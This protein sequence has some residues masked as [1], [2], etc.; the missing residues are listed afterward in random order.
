MLRLN[1][2]YLSNLLIELPK[3]INIQL[4][5][6]ELQNEI[7]DAMHKYE[8]LNSDILFFNSIYYSYIQIRLKNFHRFFP[9][10]RKGT[11]KCDNSKNLKI[12]L[13]LTNQ[14]LLLVPFIILYIIDL[15][16]RPQLFSLGGLL[17][18]LSWLGGVYYILFRLTRKS[19]KKF[20][21]DT[22]ENYQLKQT[23][24]YRESRKY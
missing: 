14:A 12:E 15:L 10:I 11:I 9:T 4:Y 24:Y 18:S 19:F 7:S 16:I 23:E 22:I 8:V 6:Y 13:N 5:M 1:K 2:V 21:A 3:N 20:I 17:F